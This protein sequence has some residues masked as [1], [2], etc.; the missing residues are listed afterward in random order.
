MSIDHNSF[1]KQ[2]E[3]P[4]DPL[5]LVH[6]RWWKVEGKERAQS[7]A[8]V[9]GMLTKDAAPRL[10]DYS[11]SARLYGNVSLSG[12]NSAGFGRLP[13]AK[14]KTNERLT[15]NVCQ[16]TVDAIQAKISKNKPK[17]LFLTSG[18][19]YKQKRKAQKLNQFCAGIFYENKAY[20][21][22]PLVFRDGTIF[23]TGIVYVFE[24]NDRVK[25]ERVLPTEISIDD[26]ESLYGEPRQM[27]RMKPV[28]RDVLCEMF[29]DQVEDIS[30]ADAIKPD[31]SAVSRAADQVLVKES[32]HLRSGPEAK[33]G[34]H[35]ITMGDVELFSEEY[36]EDTFPF[37]FFHWSKPQIGFWGQSL[38]QQLKSI[39][40]EINKLLQKVQ[41]S[42]HLGGTFKILLENGSK[43]LKEALN[44]DIGTIV[45]YTGTRPDYVAP[46]IIQPEIY[47]QIRELKA[48]AFELAGIS[49]LTASSQKPA[50][51]DSG[52]ALREYN[53]IE[54]DRLQTVG[55]AYE[56]MFLDLAHLAIR[57][58]VKIYKRK[59]SYKVKVASKSFV[60]TIDWKDVNVNV[61]DFVT[62]CFPISSLP[63]DP[64][65]RL[66]TI[67]N[68]MQAGILT[69]R[70]GRRLLDYPDLDAI[71]NL[72]NAPEEYLHMVF[73]KIVDDGELTP[74]EPHDDLQL[75]LQ[76]ALQYYN[77]Y[78]CWDL[79]EEKLELFRRYIAQNKAEQQAAT[80]PPPGAVPPGAPIATPQTPPTS[81]LLPATANS[82]PA[83]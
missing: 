17:P 52:E 27:H 68:Y 41:L 60:D 18:G 73:E 56:Q 48:S 57:T 69:M 46:P 6:S 32:W 76:L 83:A 70:E 13:S 38:V 5:L 50:G 77:L 78:R 62:H 24:H 44:N 19:N 74:P 64:A 47:N 51:L 20:A 30:K 42:L 25:F 7:I 15:Y 59:K 53:N 72:S 66:E 22:G 40:L 54:S 21:L 8:S 2:G 12:L 29:P 65:G 75:G 37:V 1:Y 82:A 55:Q 43:V 36:A 11:L 34:V 35:S 28:D 26:Q 39:Q 45:T 58:A 49:A 67:Q 14:A 4:K 63:Q 23:G 31:P 61:E 10:Q 3:K 16:S 79:E 81:N 33:D 9:L 80:Q 71:E